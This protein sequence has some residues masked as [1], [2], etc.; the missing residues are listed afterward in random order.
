MGPAVTQG[1]LSGQPAKLILSESHLEIECENERWD[2]R[3]SDIIAIK[4]DDE[5]QRSTST[6]QLYCLGAR[7]N[8]TQDDDASFSSAAEHVFWKFPLTGL[9]ATFADEFT[10]AQV[11][12][13]LQGATAEG[14]T[15]DV[16][17]VIS[18]LSGTQKAQGFFEKALKPLMSE[19]QL[20]GYDLRVTESER[21]VGELTKSIFIPRA[22]EGINQT[23]ILLSGDGGPV[24]MINALLSGGL[25]ANAQ[26]PNI[27][28]LPMGTGNALAHSS[29]LTGDTTCGLRSLL[30]GEP[31]P[32]PTFRVSLARSAEF[33][34]D[35]GRGRTPLGSNEG[36]S[37]D[38]RGRTQI[39]GA[40]VCSWGLHASLVAASD[41]AEYRK[42]GVDRF[43]MA[44]AELMQPK[45]GSESHRYRG[46]VSLIRRTDS[47]EEV[48]QIEREEHMYV[49]V[50]MV[51][52]FEE[53]FC[54]S[55]SS[56]P[57]D[58][59]M[60][61]VYF[62]VLA[63]TEVMRILGLAYQ[64]GKHV[65]VKAVTYERVDGLRIEFE[66]EEERW[67]QICVD[68]KI[69]VVE[70]G[71]WIEVRREIRTFATLIIP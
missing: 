31:K 11:P 6:Q 15:V 55:P 12:A 57:L 69:I 25:N 64:G 70:K 41:T 23:I 38:D 49:L 46:R 27:G 68:G 58:G 53:Y 5:V 21:S 63:P 54:I 3:H 56:R 1:T 20:S 17:V 10:L 43:K 39:Y 8:R 14:G 34:N 35:E 42:H 48:M 65:D 52:N 26:I 66:E 22:N 19:L 16:H 37:N 71:G 2:L 29:G 47:G 33:V 32:L 60:R 61:L 24:D 18:T 45:D 28:L 7:R 4:I 62:G 9:P 40:V 50:T 44:A 59:Q 30:R 51:S 67:R 36:V 13:H